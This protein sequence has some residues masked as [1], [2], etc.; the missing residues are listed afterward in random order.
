[1]GSAIGLAVDRKGGRAYV[2]EP[3]ARVIEV[4]LASGKVGVNAP[5]LAKPAAAAKEIPWSV[6]Q[7]VPLRP[8]LLGITGIRRAPGGRL[9]P[10]G[11][12]LLDTR[13]RSLRLLEPA[14]TGIARVGTT[15]LAFQPSFDQLGGGIPAIGLRGY[16]FEGSIRFQA[17]DG[18]PILSV[19]A[20]G[21]YAYAAGPTVIDLRDG[22]VEPPDPNGISVSPFE[23]LVGQS[24]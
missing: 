20:Q 11:L 23:L 22:R 24:S 5:A 3:G 2:V 10:L 12:R 9:R 1:M 18:R 19:R 17:L 7:A 4:D 15:L 8:G 16:S 6:V 21:R 14:A 13:S